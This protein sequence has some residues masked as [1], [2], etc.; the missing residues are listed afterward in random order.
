MIRL[1]ILDFDTSH[2]VAFTTRLNH[3]GIAK[4]QWVDGAKVVIG[5]P[6][7]SAMMPERIAGY[8]K[9]MEK[10]GVP[11]VEKPAD[12]IGKVDGMLIES[13]EGAAHYERARPFLEARI[14]CFIDKPFTCSVADAKK[15]AALAKK[16]KVGVFSASSLRY[17][18]DLVKFL[19]D[20]GKA[21]VVGALAYGPASLHTKDPKRNPGLYNYGIHVLEILYALMGPG[22][23]R[24]TNTHEKDVDVATGQWRG[25]RVATLRGVRG[26]KVGYGFVAFTDKGATAVRLKADLI[27]RELL[28]QVVA[29]F[30]DKKAPVDVEETV[31]MMAFIEAAN[32]SGA[33]H[34]A[35]EKVGG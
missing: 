19:A 6:G 7:E 20:A 14:P 1:G 23:Q 18:P 27:Y 15:I 9:Q 33:N 24:V 12:M 3:K 16:K 4:E 8:K 13:Q 29:F 30:K 28:K 10:L 21:K 35:G 32:K 22:C 34:G 25:G 26:S 11:L 2:V 5:C 31:E 17:D